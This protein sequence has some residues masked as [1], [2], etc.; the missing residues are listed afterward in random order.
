MYDSVH[1]AGSKLDWPSRT[2]QACGSMARNHSLQSVNIASIGMIQQEYCLCALIQLISESKHHVHDFIEPNQRE[3]RHALEALTEAS[4]RVTNENFAV[5]T[6]MTSSDFQA[7]IRVRVPWPPGRRDGRECFSNF[8]SN[9]ESS[10]FFL[11][12]L[13]SFKMNMKKKL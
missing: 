13:L 11:P 3:G 5:T 12:T 10:F 6:N 4:R 2:G 9:F 1:I 7:S 8:V